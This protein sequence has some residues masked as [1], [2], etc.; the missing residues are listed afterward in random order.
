[1]PDDVAALLREGRAQ[2]ALDRLRALLAQRPGAPELNLQAAQAHAL[3]GRWEPSAA[4][5]DLVLAVLPPAHPAWPDVIASRAAARLALGRAAEA[6][7]DA[8]SALARAP[9]RFAAWLNLGLARE[10][11]GD[12]RAACAAFEQALRLRPDEARAEHALARCL[13]RRGDAHHRARPLLERVLARDPD[14]AEARLLLAN[15]LSNDAEIEA[16]DAQYAELLRRH[17][18]F[19][20]AHSTWLIAQQYDPRRSPAELADAHRAWAARHAPSQTPLRTARGPGQRL[21]IGW[22]SPRFAEGPLAAFFLPV[23]A[24][25]DRR[26]SEHFLYATHPAQGAVGERFRALA[27]AWCELDEEAPEIAA[28]RLAQDEL[29]VLVDLAGHAPGNRLRALA[30]H[31]AG[32][33]VSW[34]DYFCTTGLSS[35]D[36]FISD[37]ELSPPG[38]EVHFSER[39]LRLPHGRLCYRPWIEAPEPA[40]RNP[41]DGIVFGCFNRASKLGDGVLAAWAG[42]AQHVPSARFALRA[43][44]FD[45]AGARDVFRQRCARAG[46]PPERVSLHGYSDY[47]SVLAAYG[48]IDIALDPFPFAGCATSC[49]ALW[50]GVPVVSLAGDTLVSRQSAAILRPLGLGDLVVSTVEDYVGI[51]VALAQDGV[52]RESLRTSLR[53]RL[54]ALHDPTAFSADLEALLRAELTRVARAG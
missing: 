6:A 48:G 43:G 3:L 21:R 18:D 5:Y 51:A 1:M 22:L 9:E 13:A 11:L 53:P 2:D 26:R 17:P 14:D 8:E 49:D 28:R 50:M 25:F 38:D 4:H 15:A 19:H 20:Q 10:R 7:A 32:L 44:A 29:D 24:A 39:L 35:I 12:L 54:A 45:D 40:S 34:L 42:I 23:L 41:D 37:V 36:L 46:L 31:P 27:D 16:A 30:W 47:R 52:R 33:V